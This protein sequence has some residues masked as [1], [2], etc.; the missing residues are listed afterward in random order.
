MASSVNPATGTTRGGIKMAGVLAGSEADGPRVSGL[1]DYVTTETANGVLSGTATTAQLAA[2]AALK[3]SAGS[4]AAEATVRVSTAINLS[5]TTF[6]PVVYQPVVSRPQATTYVLSG[7]ILADGPGTSDIQFRWTVPAGATISG[8]LRGLSASASTYGQGHRFQ[9]VQAASAALGGFG[10]LGSTPVSILFE[11]LVTIPAGVSG[12]VTLEGA[13]VAAG[14]VRVLPGSWLRALGVGVSGPGGV[15][16]PGNPPDPDDPDPDPTGI[17][18]ARTW[19]LNNSFGLVAHFSARAYVEKK[20]QIVELA[21]FVGCWNFRNNVSMG[22]DGNSTAGLATIRA[23]AE[24]GGKFHFTPG[25]PN[26]W[27]VPADV[28]AAVKQRVDWVA[29]KNLKPYTLSY[30]PLNEP[31]ALG[32]GW[33]D[34]VKASQPFLYNYVRT[35][36]PEAVVMGPALL[37]FSMKNTVP[38][39]ETVADGTLIVNHMGA[40]NFHGYFVV[41]PEFVRRTPLTGP[42][43]D[44]LTM[45]QRIGLLDWYQTRMGRPGNQ[46]RTVNLYV[47]ESGWHNYMEGNQ[48]HK[49]TSKLA[50]SYYGPRNILA[51]FSQ[52]IAKTYF[53][54][55]LNEPNVTQGH[56]RNFGWFENNGD[57]K[58]IASRVGAMFAIMR[59]TGA[60]KKDFDPARLAITKTGGDTNTQW[61]LFQRSDGRYYVVAWQAES[62][63]NP[64]T[65]TDITPQAKKT[66]T[67]T[68]ANRSFSAR[69][70]ADL[71]D[72]TGV[73]KNATNGNAT[74]R[75]FSF[76]VGPMPTIL[77]LIPA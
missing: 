53:Y 19:D 77:E 52:R 54:E 49:P 22:N 27:R 23:L 10:L 74:G 67:F 15:G 2:G 51:N 16:D 42:P 32:S 12:N 31:D 28:E 9:A 62:V 26:N 7:A 71:E 69:L 58:P 61:S 18:P 63:W 64:T 66:V 21:N 30:E 8:Y 73:A 1:G 35:N 50:A 39:I 46:P 34:M 29:A 11:V 59:D 68:L 57:P 48:D 14:A 60:R 70:Y 20:D 17:V 36:H 24:V 6:A 65:L 75:V 76:Q 41:P 56:E 72:R 38:Q 37:S 3:A 33:V 55:M 45:E 40:A 25:K 5:T 43:N 47:T 4:I 44:D 13:A